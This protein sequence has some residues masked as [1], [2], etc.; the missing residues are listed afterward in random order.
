MADGDHAIL[1]GVEAEWP[2]LL[3]YNRVTLREEATLLAGYD[4]DPVLAVREV[5][6]GRTLIWTSDIGPHWC[7]ESFVQWSGYGTLWVQAIAW[8]AGLE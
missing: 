7:P 1:A 4:G 6:A 5:G 3:G 2:P 8:L